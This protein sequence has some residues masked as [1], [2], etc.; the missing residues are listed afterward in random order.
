MGMGDEAYYS[1][2]ESVVLEMLRLARRGMHP[3]IR[4][5]YTELENAKAA[6]SVAIE[7]CNSI[8]HHLLMLEGLEEKA[9]EN[10]SRH[11]S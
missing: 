3:M 10:K 7:A 5:Q 11:E 6:A 2:P 1:V 8:E 9:R 4:W